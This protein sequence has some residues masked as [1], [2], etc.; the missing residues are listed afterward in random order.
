M[1]PRNPNKSRRDKPNDSLANQVG[2]WLG[3]AAKVVG[4]AAAQNPL[5][6]Q[7][8]RYG[9]AVKA[10]PTQVAK[11]AAIDLA[12]GAAGAGVGKGAVGLGRAV[13]KTGVPA[14]VV[15]K[16][17]KQQVIV[18]GGKVRGLQQIDPRS[19]YAGSDS[20]VY[21]VNPSFR[22]PAKTNPVS[23]PSRSLDFVKGAHG[24]ATEL[25]D[26]GSI[27]VAKVPK[28]SVKNRGSLGSKPSES[29]VISSAPAKVVAE[30]PV[31]PDE[32]I[33]LSRRADVIKAV[34][35]AGAK[36]PKKK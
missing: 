36:V 26:S 15:N 28:A 18:H 22:L 14:R 34:K 31:I 7:N 21:G 25:K 19:P 33:L 13:A 3:G 35:R 4:R 11:T 6:A 27:Y 32:R 10:G 12:A 20:A 1:A 24:Y 8:I 5:V 9:Q 17:T 30:I 23:E 2:G 29:I 16:I